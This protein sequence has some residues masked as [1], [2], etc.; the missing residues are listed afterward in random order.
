MNTEN[1]IKDFVDS[2]SNKYF[3]EI[4]KMKG[5]NLYFQLSSNLQLTF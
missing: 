5:S 1:D 4:G 2:Y 3:V